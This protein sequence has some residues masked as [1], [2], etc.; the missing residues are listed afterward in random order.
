ML[1][2]GNAGAN[3]AATTIAVVERRSSRSPR[4][5]EDRDPGAR[6]QRR[7]HA[8]ADRLAARRADPLLVGYDLTEPVRDAILEIPDT[9]WVPALDQD[10]AER[11]G[12]WSPRSPTALDLTGWP[13]GPRVIVRRERPHPGAQLSF[14]DHDGHRFQAILTDHDGDTGDLER[15][16]RARARVEDRIRNDKDTGLAT[17][18]SATSSTTRSGSSSR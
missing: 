4:A 18:R 7:R 14:T 8:R 16:H 15:H 3:T 10:G 9:A 13:A 1:R 12:A 2:P 5:L 6:R 17:C 11:E